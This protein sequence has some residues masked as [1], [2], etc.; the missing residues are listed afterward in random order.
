M[1]IH[2]CVC[3]YDWGQNLSS[4]SLPL[5][6]KQPSSTQQGGKSPLP[7]GDANNPHI[8][9][10]LGKMEIHLR[11]TLFTNKSQLALF[12]EFLSTICL[13]SSHFGP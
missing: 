2:G 7:S 11:K 6:M 1:H 3:Y 13:L 4:L 10:Q 5:P 8:A 9:Q 12:T